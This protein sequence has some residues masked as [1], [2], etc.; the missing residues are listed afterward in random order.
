METL[1]K[2]LYLLTPEEQKH[3]SLLLLMML[4]MALLDMIGV[5]SIIPFMAVLSDPSLIETNL[6]LKKMFDFSNIFGVEN[7]HQFLFALG[8]LVFTLLVVSLLF[9][10]LT[11]YVQSLFV[12][13]RQYSIAKRLVEGYLHQPYSWF[14]SRN[15]A[16]LGKTIL[17]E[18][19][20][21]VG[22]GMNPLMEMISKTMIAI[23]IITLLFL[24]DPKLAL[25]IGFSF[26]IAYGLIFKFSRGYLGRI[27]K[28]NL[29]NNELRFT[30]ISEAFGAAKEVKL[31]GLEK[32]YIERFSTPNKIFLKNHVLTQV[33]A[34]LPRFGL[35]AIAFGGLLL[36]ILYLMAQETSFN[37][38]LPIISLY[39]FAGYRLMPAMQ[40]IYGSFT[41]LT[42]VRPSLDKLYDDIKNLKPFNLNQ[43]QGIL[44]PKKNISLKNIYYNY[45][46]ASRTA[47]KDI[48]INIPVKTTVGLMGAT[49]S[50]KTTTVDIILGLLEAQKGNLEIDGKIVNK[51]NSKSW[52]RSIGYVP[53]HIYLADD[54][55]AANIA[56]GVDPNDINQEAVEKSSKIANLHDFIVDELPRKY[57]TTIGERGIRL[58]G[59][60]RQRI[61]IARAL[62]H[63]PQ[64][65][66]L[67]EAT[68]ALDNFT[69]EVVMDAV[70]N[71]G[72]NMTIILIAH[73]LSTLK[74]CNEIFLLEKGKLKNKGT[75]EEL[76]NVKDNL[77]MNIKN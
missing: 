5:A 60:Q 29:K 55:V 6:I 59:G 28:E 75:F 2:F 1:K 53:Q 35:E 12:H 4:I 52:Q 24:T 57:H 58:S 27:G 13:M 23:A 61:G 49:G 17:S 31:S 37:N 74:N 34:L 3:A 63:K 38:V 73:R 51:Q 68:S 18:V 22:A 69:E 72:K 10:A 32:I 33:I 16:D 70:N 48:S 19:G 8:I 20:H 47:L 42:F 14:L 66:I 21:V 40:E 7:N 45:P 26:S 77:N 36:M 39:V 30:A 15:S 67:D 25:I 64:V 9:K 65:L 11:S 62:Y 41:R 46:N 56:F 44:M 43:D 54:T 76:V 50:G 71:L